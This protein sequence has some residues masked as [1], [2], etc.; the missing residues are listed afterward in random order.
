MN[1]LILLI[2]VVAIAVLFSGL[3]V[4]LFRF[5]NRILRSA[6]LGDSN[7]DLG[8]FI[9]QGN[10]EVIEIEICID[11]LTSNGPELLEGFLEWFEVHEEH[12]EILEINQEVSNYSCLLRVPKEI[13]E[14]ISLQWLVI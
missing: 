1:A 13:V 5:V 7:D 12:L 14:T 2:F 8:S 11:L 4:K 10:S 3:A 9:G 6:K